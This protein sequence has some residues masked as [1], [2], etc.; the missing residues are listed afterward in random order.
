MKERELKF[1]VFFFLLLF[2]SFFSSPLPLFFSDSMSVN[3]ATASGVG[4]SS[5]STS[6]SVAA[7]ASVS[8]SSLPPLMGSNP[9]SKM[10]RSN[11]SAS[12]WNS[13][14]SPGWSGEEMQVLR[15]ALMKLGVGNWTGIIESGCLPG[16]TTS[17][18][19]NQ[20][21]R[22]L[23]KQSTAEFAGLHMDVLKVG[24]LNSR[25]EGPGITRKSGMIIN[26]GGT[27]P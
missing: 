16:K 11:E 5:T 3:G 18:L 26:T 25:L 12:L 21:Q 17:Q 13:T 27:K 9:L 14:L 20:T 24:E 23:G 7:A 6:S 19:N 2:F 8:A 15:L 4:A 22:M 1:K 10:L